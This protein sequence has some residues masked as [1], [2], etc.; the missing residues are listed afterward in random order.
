MSGTFL[1]DWMGRPIL[2]VKVLAV[3][4]AGAP[5]G[6]VWVD[7]TF[8]VP[9]GGASR[10]R[11]TQLDGSARFHWGANPGIG[12]W[13]LCADNLTLAGYTYA[14]GDNVVTCMDWTY[15]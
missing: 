4:Q 1:L 2:K 7:A 6:H 5:L 15:P 10:G 14:P 9:G 8:T 11:Y 3:D 13:T 12:T